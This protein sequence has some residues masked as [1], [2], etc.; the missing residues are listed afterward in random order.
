MV[1]APLAYASYARCCSRD[2]AKVGLAS[3]SRMPGG[4]GQDLKLLHVS[5]SQFV[6]LRVNTPQD[7]PSDVFIPASFL[8]SRE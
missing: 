8:S 1:V 2:A 7:V 3:A 4:R 6:A 5:H